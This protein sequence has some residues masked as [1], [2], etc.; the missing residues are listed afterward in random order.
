M[1]KKPDCAKDLE[2]YVGK[3]RKEVRNPCITAR[4]AI[5]IANYIDRL[6]SAVREKEK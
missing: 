1:D 3:D 4:E 6:E 5:K 2:Q